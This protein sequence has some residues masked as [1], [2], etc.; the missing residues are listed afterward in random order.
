MSFFGGLAYDTVITLPKNS[1]S[2]MLKIACSQSS[3]SSNSTIA[4]LLPWPVA[5]SKGISTDFISPNGINAALTASSSAS[6]AR[7][8]K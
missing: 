7:L 6:V 2:F 3:A 4:I 1:D 8:P 5:W